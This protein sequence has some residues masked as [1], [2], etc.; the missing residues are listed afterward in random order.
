LEPLLHWYQPAKRAAWRNLV[1]VRRDFPQA[2]AVGIATLFN[3]AGDKY[4]LIAVIKYRWQVIYLR[5]I[6]THA[7]YNKGKWKL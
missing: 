7:E 5:H 6:L 1:D 3:I 4:R 2:D